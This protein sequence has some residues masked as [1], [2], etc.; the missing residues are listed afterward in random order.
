M[1]CEEGCP[2][3][4]SIVDRR[5]T[6]NHSDLI[7]KGGKLKMAVPLLKKA[8]VR[9]GQLVKGNLN[10]HEQK[11]QVLIEIG[12]ACNAIKRATREFSYLS[13]HFYFQALFLF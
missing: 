5:R 7:F 12:D 1:L 4:V 3:R 13:P 6:P 8:I 11:A 10:C 2:N 9:Y